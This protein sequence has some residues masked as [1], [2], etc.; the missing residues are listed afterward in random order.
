MNNRTKILIAIT[1]AMFGG[2][3]MISAV[4]VALPKISQ[5]FNI[6][7]ATLPWIT[8]AFFLASSVFMLPGGRLSD[9]L[10]ARRMFTFGFI[11][12]VAASIVSAFSVSALMLILS[13]AFQG[14]GVGLSNAAAAVV[15]IS[16][17]PPRETGKALGIYLAAVYGGLTIGPLVGGVLTQYLGWRSIFFVN[18]PLGLVTLILLWQLRKV[19]EKAAGGKFDTIGALVS[20]LAIC[21]TIYGLT[22]LPS[23]SGILFAAGGLACMAGFIWWEKRATSPLLNLKI[24]N[25][26]RTFVFSNLAAFINYSATFALSLVIS[27][28]LQYIKGFSPQSAGLI[29]AVLT[30]IETSCTPIAGYLSDRVNLR[31][32]TTT[33]MIFSTAGLVLLYFIDSETSIMYII[34]AL[35]MTGIGL[36]FF[37]TPNT[38]AIMKSVPSSSA[39]IASASLSIMRQVGGMIGLAIITVV[40]SVLIGQAEITPE[41]YPSLLKGIKFA[42][43]IFA[44]LSFIGIFASYARN[45]K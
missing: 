12:L 45:S 8:T 7:A 21:L 23:Q 17:Y 1:C 31:N 10:G 20:G 13:R 6:G 2:S 27:L 41:Y 39:G 37:V 24:F 11:I 16:T 9:I 29:L 30:L 4:N 43:G 32:L 40:L 19:S 25:N 38:T 36:G 44:V 26:N 35:V 22:Q 18:V 14:I 15:I 42:L 28:Y 5:E 3:L 33:G 34:T